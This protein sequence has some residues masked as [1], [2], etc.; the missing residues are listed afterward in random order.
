MISNGRK[1]FPVACKRLFGK[2]PRHVSL[3]PVCPARLLDHLIRLE[4]E[5]R[6]DR[7]AE[8]LG[9]LEVDDQLEPRGLSQ[10][11]LTRPSAIEDLCDLLGRDPID[12]GLG[13]A[14]GDQPAERGA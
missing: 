8:G 3:P 13:R 10:R 14:L 2:A 1:L 9:G 6:R 11:Q 12:L 5:R 4:E 7:K